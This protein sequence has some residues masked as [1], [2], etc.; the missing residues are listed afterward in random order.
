MRLWKALLLAPA[1]AFAAAALA[2]AA[3]GLHDTPVAAGAIVVLGN[4]VL[5]SGQPSPRLQAR[6]DCALDAYRRRLAPWVIVSGGVGKEGFDEAAVM[7]AYLE[8]HG[9]PHRA[10]LQDNA[11]NDTA[12]SAANVARLAAQHHIA[13]VLLAS[14][15]FHL[16]RA[17]LAFRR[18]GMRVAG[19]IHARYAEPRDLY[20]LAREV[21][22]YAAYLLGHKEGAP[23]GATDGTATQSLAD[24][25]GNKV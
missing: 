4:T 8:R 25:D 16:P 17:R 21:V 7:A 10:L 11:G 18:A 5:P 19:T 22:G 9:V 3:A 12:A 20:S 13:S 6:L 24:T 23:P 2:I 1:L 14:Q 15:Y